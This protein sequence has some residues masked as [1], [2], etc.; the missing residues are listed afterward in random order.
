MTVTIFFRWLAWLL[1]AAIVALTLS[2]L[3]L[4]PNPEMSDRLERFIAFAVI[5]GVFCL[6][7]PKHRIHIIVLVIGMI[8]LLEVAQKFIPGRH[9][10]LLRDGMPKVSGTLCGA[11]IAILIEQCIGRFKR[12]P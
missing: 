11:M 12:V 10:R 1:V 2:P 4:R 7:Y 9:G 3:E 6:G 8:G 5:A